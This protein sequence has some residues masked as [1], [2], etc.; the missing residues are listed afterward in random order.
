[1][2]SQLYLS[3]IYTKF[4]CFSMPRFRNFMESPP[5]GTFITTGILTSQEWP[6]FS[7]PLHPCQVQGPFHWRVQPGILRLHKTNTV[8]DG[9]FHDV[10]DSFCLNHPDSLFIGAFGLYTLEIFY[11][12][13][14]LK[15]TKICNPEN[16]GKTKPS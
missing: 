2:S 5:A 11:G 7:G 3:K 9:E 10:P 14:H 1:M 6:S 15:K 4:C 8:E 12:G 13:K 16:H